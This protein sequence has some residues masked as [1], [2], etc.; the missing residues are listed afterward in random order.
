[1]RGAPDRP[2]LEAA[3]PRVRTAASPGST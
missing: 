1:V 2:T 3:R